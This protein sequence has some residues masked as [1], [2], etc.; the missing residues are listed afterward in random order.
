M[1]KA[2]PSPQASSF[3]EASAVAE[4][5]ADRTEDETA[6]RSPMPLA[7]SPEAVL[8]SIAQQ[9]CGLRFRRRL[10]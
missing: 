10:P 7:L 2:Q 5:M 4:A 9:A 1:G 3:A 6:G 8:D